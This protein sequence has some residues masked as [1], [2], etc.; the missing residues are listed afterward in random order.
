MVMKKA[1]YIICV[2][3]CLY[4]ILATYPEIV[5]YNNL[6]AVRW[7]ERKSN[8][9][10]FYSEPSYYGLYR[11]SEQVENGRVNIDEQH[12]N[13]RVS[14][15]DLY[16]IY[17]NTVAENVDKNELTTKYGWITCDPN[18]TLGLFD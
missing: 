17:I 13:R 5:K 7:C 6:I 15:D 12:Y 14:F 9:V 4:I 1:F 2:L 10:I 11:Y 16:R 3:W 8:S 18:N